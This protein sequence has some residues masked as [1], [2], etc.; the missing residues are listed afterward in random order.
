MSAE[1]RNNIYFIMFFFIIIFPNFYIVRQS[2][3]F[4]S[5]KD[6]QKFIL[7]FNLIDGNNHGS[8]CSRPWRTTVTSSNFGTFHGYF[9]GN[10]GI[11]LLLETSQ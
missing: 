5:G 7:T 1:D 11:I 10:F 8:N 3:T 2:N 9:S 4:Y 6:L